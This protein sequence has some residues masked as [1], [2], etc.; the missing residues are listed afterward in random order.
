MDR[1]GHLFPDALEQLTDCLDAAGR[2][3]ERTQHGPSRSMRWW[4]CPRVRWDLTCGE[5]VVG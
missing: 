4:G 1:Y 2:L 3:L 5:R